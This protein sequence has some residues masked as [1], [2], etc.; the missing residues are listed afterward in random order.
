MRV[1][2][3]TYL[4]VIEECP[5]VVD[6]SADAVRQRPLT[7]DKQLVPGFLETQ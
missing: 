6:A 4:R 2:G 1:H 5:A 7:V 3:V